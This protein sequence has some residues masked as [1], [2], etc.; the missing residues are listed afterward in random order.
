MSFTLGFQG[1]CSSVDTACSSAL[2]ALRG[3]ATDVKDALS[4]PYEG[5]KEPSDLALAVSLKLMPHNTLGMASAGM[6]SI[7]GRCKTLDAC[8]NGM[9]RTEGVG[10]L[11]LEPGDGTLTL[12]NILV[13][14]D[15]RSA[16][17][18]AP[19]GTAQRT[20]LVMALGL[21]PP[22]QLGCLEM[23]G[24]GTALGD[25]TEAGA[26]THVHGVSA[27]MAPLPPLG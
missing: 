10:A 5:R 16:S 20:L 24:T 13:R 25:P 11:V 3:A 1:P 27:R 21:M 8:A 18:T 22:T 7:D 12:Q 26:M 6:L 17:L 9:V 19:N 2:V 15:G 14:Q 23:H 4:D